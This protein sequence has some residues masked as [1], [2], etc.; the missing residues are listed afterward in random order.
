MKSLNRL[1]IRFFRTNHFIVLTSLLS[2]VIAVSLI[3]TL[4]VFSSTAKQS[5]QNE[6]KALFG[7]QD[8]AVVY[9]SEGPT[10]DENALY[11]FVAE[12]PGTEKISE[13]FVTRAFVEP[14]GGNVYTVGMGNDDL[15]RSRYNTTVDLDNTSVIMSEQLAQSLQINV[16]DQVKIENDQFTL[17]EIIN[18]I[19]GAGIVPDM[20]IFSLATA[21]AF[22][23]NNY[24][25]TTT[26][27][28]IKA[29]TGTDVVL[30]AVDL[31]KF[32]EKLRIDVMEQ[33]EFVKRNMESLIV[34][35][36]VMAVLI[37]LV[38]SMMVISNFDL[39]LY[40]NRNQ[41]AI[42][43]A[44]G[45]RAKQIAK[46]VLIQSTLINAAGTIIGLFLAS[47]GHQI[48]QPLFQRLFSIEVNSVSFAWAVAVPI[49]VG[50]AVVIQIFL[51][52]PV[53][54]AT[55]ALPI[56]L[57]EEN[58]KIDFVHTTRRRNS[59]LFALA[60]SVIAIMFGI[61][62]ENEEGGK[63]LALLGG[64]LL[65]I[66]SLFLML[67]FIIMPILR[68][69][70]P[71]A[72]VLLGK[73]AVIAIQ[74]M[75]PQIRKNTLIILSISLV[76]TIT[77]FG[78]VLLNTIQQ[79][80]LAYIHK[81][82]PTSVVLK[83]RLWDSE[84][85]TMQLMKEVEE[86]FPGH[87]V[88]A[89]SNAAPGEI[90]LP[91]K[92]VEFVYVLTDFSQLVTVG[93]LE[94]KV[95]DPT[96]EIIVSNEFAEKHNLQVGDAYM[97][98]V[99]SNTSYQVEWID[100][101]VVGAISNTLSDVDAMIDWEATQFMNEFTTFHSLLIDTDEEE[102][103]LSTLEPLKRQ[104]PEL[105][106]FGRQKSVDEADAMFMQRW[107]IF[108]M[109]LV[110]LVLSVMTGVC[111]TLVNTIYS[112]RKEF[113][114]LRTI[115]VRP[116]GIVKVILTQVVLYVVIG[117]SFGTVCGLVLSWIISLIDP[118]KLYVNAALLWSVAGIMIV[119]SVVLF[120]PIGHKLAT[121]QISVEVLQDNK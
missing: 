53:Y 71:V 119:M 23:S 83:S 110:A 47:F 6:M 19:E 115:G 62:I 75:L 35:I 93:L 105:Q 30:M 121:R 77:V 103:I 118:G 40:K 82:F 60:I 43:R 72:K 41:F 98:G 1:A 50:S 100:Q 102:S 107:S 36:G 32:D 8:L 39:L 16:G 117:L 31:Q 84:I 70:M 90:E 89:I 44:M 25:L 5:L 64:G 113:A 57:F 94:K 13:V 20:V 26:A 52:I 88:N 17:V 80:G 81:Q 38:T 65:F 49:A 91:G 42:M 9:D 33:E 61:L 87:A 56:Q 45:A 28:M 68:S 111:N 46:I 101:M 104:Y 108:I 120:V 78:S 99:Y 73:E 85:P 76:M 24:E 96:S 22:P 67:P 14:L 10:Y 2:I 27:L 74:T 58:E 37:L 48:L 114:V 11:N 51:A 12:H 63:A 34:F 7:E 54:K 15:A 109:V 3:V 59:A 4:A 106:L 21:K 79:N 95:D 29:T 55:K 18:N 97:I 66:V 69:T 116:A 92:Q 112:K 86:Q